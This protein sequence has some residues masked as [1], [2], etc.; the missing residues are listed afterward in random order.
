VPELRKDL[1]II[2]LDVNKKMLS[3]IPVD[4]HPIHADGSYLPFTSHSFDAAICVTSLEFMA[5]P[6]K[7]SG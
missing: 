6:K 3:T 2:A 1:S 7:Q 5:H 4:L